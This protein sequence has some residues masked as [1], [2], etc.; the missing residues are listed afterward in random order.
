M[1]EVIV[2]KQGYNISDGPGLMRASGTITLVKGNQ[3]IIVDTGSPWDKQLIIDGLE[4][5]GLKPE[6]INFVVCTHGHS[7]HVGNNNLFPNAVHIMSYDVCVGDQYLLHQFDQGIPYEIDDFVEVLP[8]PGHTGRDVSVIVR[9]TAKGTIAIAGDLFECFEDLEDPTIWQENSEKP[10][11][12]EANRIGILQ[13]AD[14]IIPGHGEMFRVPDSYKK[15]MSV[16]FFQEIKSHI[17]V[18]G[19]VAESSEY[20]VYEESADEGSIDY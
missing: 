3:N 1:Y 5:F 2:L 10:E 13:L 9:D 15:Q 19:G 4:K 17:S 8:T 20:L 14:Y 6:E 12:Q 11:E 18:D 7:D 16:V